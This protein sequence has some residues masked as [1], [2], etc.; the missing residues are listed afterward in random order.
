MAGI[1]GKKIV[2][3]SQKRPEALQHFTMRSIAQIQADLKK[4]E[5]EVNRLG[6]LLERN[7]NYNDV[8]FNARYA[9]AEKLFEQLTEE[10]EAAK[11][12]QE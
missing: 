8:D 3:E 2:K 4:A 9:D 12:E 11:K 5:A 1:I 7:D 6:R 10:L